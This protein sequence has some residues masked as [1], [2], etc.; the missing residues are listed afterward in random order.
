[1]TINFGFNVFS[2]TMILYIK[3][4]TLATNCRSALVISFFYSG[5][6]T[7]FPLLVLYTV[8]NIFMLF[9]VIDSFVSFLFLTTS[10]SFRKSKVPR[11]ASNFHDVGAPANG[12]FSFVWF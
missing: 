10:E 11:N 1:M 3:K 5:M 6:L 7:F 8:I 2:L 12:T 9:V 4:R